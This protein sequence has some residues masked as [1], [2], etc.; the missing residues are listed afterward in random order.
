VHP[1]KSPDT[2]PSLP[3]RST[4]CSPWLSTITAPTGTNSPRSSSKPILKPYVCRIYLSTL[5]ELHER[6]KQYIP[7][8]LLHTQTRITSKYS[9][10][11]P[12]TSKISKR[13]RY[14]AKGKPK[15]ASDSQNATAEQST[16]DPATALTALFRLKAYDPVSGACLQYQTDKA[17]EVGRLIGTLGRLARTMGALPDSTTGTSR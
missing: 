7:T 1:R 14:L 12:T 4:T 6:L 16:E 17:A 15:S 13:Q 8:Y 2:A 3:C 9:V 5:R 10:L 11:K